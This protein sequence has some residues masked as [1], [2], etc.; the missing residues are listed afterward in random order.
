MFSVLNRLFR[1]SES[2]LFN[3]VD[4]NKLVINLPLNARNYLKKL[5]EQEWNKEKDIDYIS[6]VT[7]D[8]ND[9]IVF[10]TY[11][12][13]AP[14]IKFFKGGYTSGEGLVS[15]IRSKV[16]F[17]VFWIAQNSRWRNWILTEGVVIEKKNKY[18]T[19]QFEFK[20]ND[21]Y[22]K[23]ANDF[24]KLKE[25]LEKKYSPKSKWDL[26]FRLKRKITKRD[27]ERLSMIV[28]HNDES[29]KSFVYGNRPSFCEFEFF[30]GEEVL[31]KNDLHRLSNTQSVIRLARAINSLVSLSIEFRRMGKRDLYNWKEDEFIYC[32]TF[33]PFKG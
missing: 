23:M 3:L 24:S 15:V 13:Y 12:N 32:F 19:I 26:Y 2:P 1:G 14:E 10:W 5:S 7:V 25:S 27:V 31:M 4:D 33:S 30:I 8:L 20:T 16:L 9:S 11:D 6:I 28:S 17:E 29:L 22:I 21:Y 18:I